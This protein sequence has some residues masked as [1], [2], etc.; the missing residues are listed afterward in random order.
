MLVPVMLVSV[1]LV[2]VMLV[3]ANYAFSLLI[4]H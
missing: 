3:S 2:P 1:M 4:H